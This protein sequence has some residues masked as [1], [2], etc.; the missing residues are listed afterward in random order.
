MLFLFHQVVLW[1]TFMGNGYF[2]YVSSI[3]YSQE[4]TKGKFP[5]RHFP[6]E[7]KNT[8]FTFFLVIIDA[9]FLTSFKCSFLGGTPYPGVSLEKLFELLKSGYRMEKPLNCPENM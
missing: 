6:T 8:L 5:I 9:I 3:L 1:N 2:W 4:K 7:K